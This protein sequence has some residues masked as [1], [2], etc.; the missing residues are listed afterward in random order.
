MVA[1]AGGQTYIPIDRQT[2]VQTDTLVR[3]PDKE[4]GRQHKIAICQRQMDCWTVMAI[5]ARLLSD[6]DGWNMEIPLLLVFSRC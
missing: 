5:A 1:Q 3:R 4:T 6:V 2:S